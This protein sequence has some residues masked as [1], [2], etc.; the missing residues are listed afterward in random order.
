MHNDF[1]HKCAIS[2]VAGMT[3][4]KNALASVFLHY[5]CI[6]ALLLLPA[7][8]VAAGA[9]E[10]DDDS[11]Y[12]PGLVATYALD[13]S[14]VTRIDE[15][16]AFDWQ[17]ATCDPRLPTGELK[18]AWRGRLWAR[19]A[20]THRLSCFTQGDVEIKLAGKTVISGRTDQPQWLTS[21][22]LDLEFDYHPLEITFRRTQPRGQLALFWSGPDFRLE[23][24]PERALVHERE[25]HPATDFERGRQLAAALR[26]AACHVDR[27]AAVMP[28]PALDRLSGNVHESWLIDWLSSHEGRPPTPSG[29][30]A[31]EAFTSAAA[32]EQS[33]SPRRMPDLAMTKPEAEAVAAW[34][35]REPAAKNE[36]KKNEQKATKEEGKSKKSE[37]KSGKKSKGEERPKPSAEL[38]ERL[39]LMSGCLACHQLGQLGESEIG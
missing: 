34:L 9:D 14:S 26:C 37:A 39:V 31:R 17:D 21:P 28:A 20:G 15:V 22:P 30:A 12:T 4:V 16:V 13:A 6:A 7:L 24:V 27:A 35:L 1:R 29:P 3:C 32:N 5:A 36:T 8:R 23:P 18:A 2:H 33:K 10:D 11:P 38:G 25:Q 19:S